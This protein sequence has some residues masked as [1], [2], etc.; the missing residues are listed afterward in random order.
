MDGEK[1]GRVFQLGDECEF[2]FERRRDMVGDA[3][4]ITRLRALARERDERLLFARETFAQFIRIFIGEISEAK[5]ERLDE[6]RAFLDRLRRLAKQPRHFLRALEMPLGVRGEKKARFGQ[7]RL[8]ANAG[9]RVGERAALGDVHMRVIDGDEGQGELFGECDA[10]QKACARAGPVKRSRRQP[11]AALQRVEKRGGRGA[12]LHDDDKLALA[13]IEKVLKD[14]RAV[15]LVR[16]HIAAR[17]QPAEAAVSGAVFRI[18]EDV[19]RSVAEDETRADGEAEGAGVFPMRAQIG[20]G[21]HHPRKGV[22]VG[23]PDPAMAERQRRGRH[24]LGV[25][26]AAQEGKIG[27]RRKLGVAGRWH[28]PV[29]GIRMFS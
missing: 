17:Q 19:R 9:H 14:E 1:I 18:A 20:E 27:R 22:A 16:A 10:S 11:D 26:G 6:A 28:Q 15:A 21:A 25:R 13:E 7:R 8:L 12:I 23:D 3:V 5:I 24:F 29:R 4:R 2:A